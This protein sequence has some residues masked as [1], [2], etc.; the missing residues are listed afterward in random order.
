MPF[1]KPLIKKPEINAK[2]NLKNHT[3]TF[4]SISDMID[5]QNKLISV[6]KNLEINLKNCST[7]STTNTMLLASISL[8]RKNNNKNTILSFDGNSKLMD[9]LTEINFISGKK[10]KN[11]NMEPKPFKTEE[12]IQTIL[13]EIKSSSKYAIIN[14]DERN[15]L[16]SKTYEF[17]KNF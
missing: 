3:E 6:K 11:F 14:N 13:K 5:I 8:M 10:N 16:I 12:E 7:L 9:D 4:S 2:A 17:I 15:I 1:W